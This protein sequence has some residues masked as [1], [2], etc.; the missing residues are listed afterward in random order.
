[1]KT[2]RL[3]NIEEL[4]ENIPADG[5]IFFY[6]VGYEERSGYVR[7]KFPYGCNC[8]YFDY[9]SVGIGDYDVNKA[10]AVALNDTRIASNDLS[11]RMSIVSELFSARKKN[12]FLNLWV[13]VSCL[14]RTLMSLTIISILETVLPEDVVH[15]LYAPAVFR[16]PP[17]FLAPLRRFCAATPELAGAVGNPYKDRTLIMG[18]GYEYGAALNAIDMIEPQYVELLY[19]VG[20]DERFMPYVQK[21]NFNF[22]FGNE[23]YKLASYQLKDPVSVHGRVRDL[24]F[25]VKH[26]SSIVIVPFGPKIFSAICVILAIYNKREVSFMRY[27]VESIDY[28]PKTSASGEIF[29]FCMEKIGSN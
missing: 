20:G 19:P 3:R 11:L 14:D 13:D 24:I 6:A 8:I 28:F 1:M 12:P 23:N 21:A 26:H 18:L 25:S 27:S 29:G 7:S 17:L 16:K 9:G 22:D 4:P 15:F 10:R 2:Y 5:S